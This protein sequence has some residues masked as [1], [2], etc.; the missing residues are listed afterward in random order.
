MRRS[1]SDGPLPLGL[2]SVAVVKTIR[3]SRKPSSRCH[4]RKVC[5]PGSAMVK[6]TKFPG[7]SLRL[8]AQLHVPGINPVSRTGD[9]LSSVTYSE[10]PAE[11][12][13]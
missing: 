8:A 13:T 1:L 5:I 7:T 10:S 9:W 4:R 12:G 11:L 2:Y 3:S 6:V